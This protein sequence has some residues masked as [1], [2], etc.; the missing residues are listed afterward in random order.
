MGGLEWETVQS[1]LNVIASKKEWIDKTI[2]RFIRQRA[3]EG[4]T[5]KFKR[6]WNR[7]GF[8]VFGFETNS[9]LGTIEGYE[10]IKVP[11][12]FGGVLQRKLL[13]I[14]GRRLL[15]SCPIPFLSFYIRSNGDVVLCFNDYLENNI[16]G[17]VKEMTIREIFNSERYRQVRSDSL[18]RGLPDGNVCSEC[19][20]FREGVWLTV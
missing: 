17:N 8:R 13:R 10:K 20:L 6:Y 5:R 7:K 3:N 19:D 14:I 15:P 9:R 1:N 11:K 4:Q 16:L 18:N 12:M 2:L